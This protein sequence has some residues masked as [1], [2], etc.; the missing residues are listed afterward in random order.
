MRL[1]PVALCGSVVLLAILAVGCSSST[2]DDPAAADSGLTSAV[3]DGDNEPATGQ[4]EAGLVVEPDCVS[5]SECEEQFVLDGVTYSLGCDAVLEEAVLD[6]EI[7]SGSAFDQNVRVHAID[8]YNAR[9]VVAVDIPGGECSDDDAEAVTTAWSFAFAQQTEAATISD[10]VCQVG[11]L[12]PARLTANS[13]G[14]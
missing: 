2:D 1:N 11:A 13:C 5:E 9:I 10:V 12:S 8:G 7:G 4:T 14:P 6:Q 3:A